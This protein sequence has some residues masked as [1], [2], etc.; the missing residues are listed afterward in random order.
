MKIK[1]CAVLVWLFLL[2]VAPVEAHHVVFLDFSGLNLTAF[3]T[4]DGNP[5]SPVFVRR[6]QGQIVANMIEDFAPFDIH[7]TTFAPPNGRFTRV[8]FLDFTDP[9]G[10]FGCA[11]G[12]C[13]QFGNCTGIGSFSQTQSA[14]E[15]YAGSFTTLGTT[16]TGANATTTRIANGISHTASHELGHVLGLTHC[17]AADDFVSAGAICGDGFQDSDDQNVNFH[18][19]ASGASSGLSNAQRATR[20]RFFSIH[21]E[22]RVLFKNFQVRNHW[23]PLRNVNN[24]VR[25]DLIY[26]TVISRS[27]LSWSNHLSDGDS[28]LS[29][30]S[31]GG[32][33]DPE[34]IFLQG[35][36]DG[37]GRTELVIGSAL[38]SNTMSWRVH[39]SQGSQDLSPAT[40]FSEDA[41]NIGNIYRLMD[42]D[43]DGRA[44][45]LR[46]IVDSA[47][48]VRW[49]VHLSDGTSF[50]GGTTVSSDAGDAGDLFLVGDVTGNGRDDL[51]IVGRGAA[52]RTEVHRSTG[53]RLGFAGFDA[54]F[55][56]DPDYVMLGQVDDDG[57]ADLV[58]GRVQSDRR[59]D[60]DVRK[61][62]GCT[63]LL[64]NCLDSVIIGFRDNAGDAGD[65]FR[66]GD[67]NGGGRDD[68][69]YGRMAGMNSLTASPDLSLMTWFGRRSTGSTFD[70]VI[71]WA[72]D[73][74]AEGSVIP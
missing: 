45:L 31:W 42:F 25:A 57:R 60:W 52:T 41:G 73:A 19:M 69:F 14:C 47:S 33:G 4:I 46:G 32:A 61:S 6:V 18:I 28:F 50:G 68:L 13:C 23:N 24:G 64:G 40:I 72:S 66:L 55:A 21:S 3:P 39:L 30:N 8:V 71:T 63:G 51:M 22:R 5:T 65:Q 10:L 53:S 17:H 15:I 49:V 35:D 11:G 37:D 36:V 59:V 26:G 74:G 56:F 20:D 16:F 54:H 48:T 12:T 27:L 67:G 62:N 29:R 2:G 34:D 1:S 70:S 38:S 43:G 9:T 44:D 7:F 58:T